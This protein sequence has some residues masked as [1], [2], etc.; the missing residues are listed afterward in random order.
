[1]KKSALLFALLMF[2]IIQNHA[3]TLVDI[4]GNVYNTISIGNQVWMKENLRVQHFRNG[5]AIPNIT[6]N[7]QWSNLESAAFCVYNNDTALRTTYG[8]LYNWYTVNDSNNIAPLGWH[9]PDQSEW[10]TLEAYLGGIDIAGGKMKEADTTHWISPNTGASNESG[11]TALPAGL[12]YH[13]NGQ[14]MGIGQSCNMWSTTLWGSDTLALN[15]YLSYWFTKAT[16]AG[17]WINMGYSIRCIKDITSNNINNIEINRHFKLFPNPANDRFFINCAGNAQMEIMS[18][19]GN[20][21]MQHELVKSKTEIDIS[22]LT[23]GMY[24]IKVTAPN[25]TAQQK[26]IKE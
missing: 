7:M 23:T 8:L 10:Q 2:L 16:N 12:R 26:L 1:M 22:A 13:S 11:F 18:L 21:I 17:S 9:I 19:A 5:K 24:I 6:D 14:F 4:D 3:Q 15:C 25:W 20:I